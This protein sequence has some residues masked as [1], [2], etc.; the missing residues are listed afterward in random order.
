MVTF[1]GNK[2]SY[3]FP[4]VSYRSDLPPLRW[5]PLERIRWMINVRNMRSTW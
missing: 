1:N 4:G 3:Y 2:W 5:S